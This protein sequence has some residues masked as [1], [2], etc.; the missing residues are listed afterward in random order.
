L[1]NASVDDGFKAYNSPFNLTVNGSSSSTH[2]IGSNTYITWGTGSTNYSG[3]NATNP[4]NHKLMLG[5]ADNS[6]QRI[7][8]FTGGTAYTRMRYEG[9]G[10]TS[11]TVGSPGIVLEVTFFNPADYGGVPVIEV[12]VGNHN[13]TYGVTGIC[14]TNA[15]MLQWT[16]AANTSYVLVGN[17]TGT[18]WTR[19]LGYINNSGY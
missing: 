8:T 10:S 18:S 7:S 11:G 12:L 3:L 9:N 2:Y 1:Q 4:P 5:A 13:R 15:F 16:T 6:Y 14:T 17:S 19:Y